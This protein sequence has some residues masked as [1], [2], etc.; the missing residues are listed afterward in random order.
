MALKTKNKFKFSLI[1]FLSISGLLLGCQKEIEQ[2]SSIEN[3]ASEER[4]IDLSS[5]SLGVQY[6]RDLDDLNLDQ[7]SKNQFI[8][9]VKD[10][11]Q[12]KVKLTNEWIIHYSMET[13]KIRSQNKKLISHSKKAEG[14]RFIEELLRSDSSYKKTESGLVY[15]IV[16]QGRKISEIKRSTFINMSYRS[17]HLDGQKYE[18]TII[19]TPRKLPLVGILKAWQEA[20]NLAGEDG[21]IIII[22]PPQLTYGDDGA[23]PYIEPGE[24]LKFQIRFYNIEEDSD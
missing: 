16:K 7:Q 22:A 4:P 10:T 8:Q 13:D 3:Q 9:G 5:Y 18:Q 24:Y 6:A 20:F 23:K 2:N 21:A 1:G 17:F 19:K 12:N 11:F 15:K 14:E